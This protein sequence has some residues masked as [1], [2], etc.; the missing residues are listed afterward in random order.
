MKTTRH[1]LLI[2]GSTFLAGSLFTGCGDGDEATGG[3]D[4]ADSTATAGNNSAKGSPAEL[5]ESEH[6][7]KE[8]KITGNDLMKFS[9]EEI[10]ALPGQPLKLTF[11]NVGTMP[12]VSMGHNWALLNKGVNPSAFT[13]AGFASAGNDYINPDNENDVIVRT[14]ILGPGEN[15]TITFNA[16]SESGEYT[17]V[18]TF[19]GHFAVG[20]KGVLIVE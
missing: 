19:P 1:I 9:I 11:E 13:E 3:S 17:Y 14:A 15:E 20:M 8:I 4:A 2:L 12:K 5:R 6:P 18:C 7:L 16:P 10:K